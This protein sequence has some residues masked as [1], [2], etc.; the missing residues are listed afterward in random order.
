MTTNAP[1]VALLGIGTMGA[2]MA[3]NI[4]AAG[5][6]LTVWNRSADK[7][8]PLAELGATVAPSPGA[9]VAGADLV[10]TMLF[11]AESVAEV[12]T[13][14][15]PGLGAGQL[16]VQMSTVGVEGALA[17][18]GLA[19]RL[20]VGFVDAP[21]LGTKKPAQDGTLVVLAAGS[22][23]QLD[24][25]ASLFEAVGA[26]TVR[27]GEPVDASRLKL[28]AN[29]WVL[30]MLEG[31]AESLSLAEALGLDPELFLAALRGGAMDAPY[32][33]LKGAGMI[34]GEFAPAF[35]VDG[36]AKDAGL[37]LD[38]ADTA[39]VRISPVTSSPARHTSSPCI[40]RSM[41]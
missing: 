1:H 32:V 3:R 11:D 36:A 13:A 37:I 41:P 2:G 30:A 29:A 12:M 4:L 26:R 40:S 35:S 38:A 5:L 17:L 8:A 9:A 20:G 21:V 33:Q 7:A 16:W 27:V 14:A 19:E 15:A 31:M 28:V 34:A 22:D 25:C 23:E 39:G 6:P 18:A 24:T 10:V